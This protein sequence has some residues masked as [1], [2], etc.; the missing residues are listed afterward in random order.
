MQ[1]TDLAIAAPLGPVTAQALRKIGMNVDLQSMDWQTL[2]GRRAKQDP[3]DQGGWNIFHTFW[4][5]ADMLNPVSNVGINAKG[6]KGGFFGWAEDAEIETMRNAYALESYPAKQAAIA[7]AVQERAYAVG[8]YYPT[9]QFISPLA[10]S[11][12]ADGDPRSPRRRY[13]GTSRRS[14]RALRLL[15]PFDLHP[16]WVRGEPER[17]GKCRAATG[18]HNP[19][20]I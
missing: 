6:R 5:N 4:V 18:S 9:G 3:V 8:M 10:V 15:S 17:R 11:P 2:V 19:P 14:E 12:Q 16:D 20:E 13:S 7:K 1:P